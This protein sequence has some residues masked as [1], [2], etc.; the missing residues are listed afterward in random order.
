VDLPWAGFQGW[1]DVRQ[2]T[3]KRRTR[4]GLDEAPYDSKQRSELLLIKACVLNN[5]L[6]SPR[7]SSL[8][9][10][11]TVVVRLVRGFRKKIWLVAFCGSATNPARSRARIISFAR[12]PGKRASIAT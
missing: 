4:G 3:K 9:C 12:T 1:W 2:K 8:L 10:I 6:S 11:D 5:P 7:G